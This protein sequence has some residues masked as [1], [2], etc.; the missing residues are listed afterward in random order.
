[1]FKTIY[2]KRTLRNYE[3]KTVKLNQEFVCSHLTS[4]FQSLQILL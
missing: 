3:G 1:M 4:L 2:E